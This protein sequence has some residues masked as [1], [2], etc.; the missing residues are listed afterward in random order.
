MAIRLLFPDDARSWLRR[1]YERQHRSWIAGTGSWPLAVSLGEPTER[2]V[3][4][5]AALIRSWVDAW[6]AWRD[7]EQLHWEER[8]WPRLGSQQ[9]PARLRLESG[10]D[11]ARV[12]GESARWQLAGER[13]DGLVQRWSTLAGSPALIRN[14]DLLADYAAPDFERLLALILWLEQNPRSGHYLRQLPIAGMDTKWIDGRRRGLVSELFRAI[15][16]EGEGD[17]FH[18]LC[19]LRQAPHRIRMRVLCQRLRRQVGGLGDIEA[20]IEELAALDLQ[21][22]RIVIVENL[23]TGIALPQHAGCVAFMK[24]GTGVSVLAELPWLRDRPALYWGDIDTHGF[25]ILDRARS[26]LPL[27]RSVLMDETTLLAHRAWWVEEAEPHR[28][29]DLP[30]LTGAERAVFDRLRANLWGQAVRL[31]QERIPWPA[32]ISTLR[33]A[34]EASSPFVR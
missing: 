27:A 7:P 15:R 19:G 31:E 8:R 3:V 23:E 4:E 12:V 14:L 29:A 28:D 1:R 26:A 34:L 11:V 9:L 32:A 18:E 20:P 16:G 21:P 33:E 17:D 13:Y 22:E 24:L 30:H 2:Q 25:A 6:S 10:A 5:D